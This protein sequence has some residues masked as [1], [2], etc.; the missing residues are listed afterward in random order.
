MSHGRE[1]RSGSSL[2]VLMV[3]AWEKP[4][5]VIGTMAASA[6]PATTTSA[7]PER[8]IRSAQPIASAPEAQAETGACTPALAL[9]TKPTCAAGPLGISIGTVSGDTLRRPV[10]LQQVVLA[11]QGVHATDAGADDHRQ[12]VRVDLVRAELGV[13][14]GLLRRDQRDLLG[15]VQPAGLHPGQD[16]G[17]FDGQRR[18]EGH[19]Q[20]ESLDPLEVQRPRTTASGQ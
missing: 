4:A 18:G 1:A 15:P 17:R 10:L 11:H 19:G 14:P 12:P 7:S 2:R 20:A 9:N 8:I 5:M 13:L 16:V 3:R 6:P